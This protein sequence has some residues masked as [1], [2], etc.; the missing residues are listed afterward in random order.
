MSVENILQ[1]LADA[2]GIS[3]EDLARRLTQKSHNSFASVP[4]EEKVMLRNL[5]KDEVNERMNA[6]QAHLAPASRLLLKLGETYEETYASR[7]LRRSTS[8][9]KRQRLSGELKP[10]VHYTYGGKR[11]ILYVGYQIADILAFHA[12]LHHRAILPLQAG[13]AVVSR[14]ARRALK[15]RVNGHIRL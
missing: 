4:L 5:V 13:R 9:L 15:T 12:I 14:L 10:G 2:L 6:E 7:F 8:T 3:T 1:Q 11:G